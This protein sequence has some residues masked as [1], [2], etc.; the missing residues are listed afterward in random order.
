MSHQMAEFGLLTQTE[1]RNSKLLLTELSNQTIS[2]ALTKTWP[3][4]S[5]QG[6][7]GMQLEQ[8]EPHAAVPNEINALA[9]F[10]VE[11][12]EPVLCGLTPHTMVKGTWTYK[13]YNH[14]NLPLEPRFL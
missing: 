5:R 3:A 10:G 2:Q 11:I 6:I 14:L 1:R 4:F 9:F 12:L 13:R 7:P 8:T